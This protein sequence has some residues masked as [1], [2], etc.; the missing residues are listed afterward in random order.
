MINDLVSIIT[1]VYNGESWIL[2]CIKS[3]QN[4][5][6]KNWEMLIVDDFSTDKTR[7]VVR[8]TLI[9]QRIRLYSN[10]EN[11]GVS[12]SRNIAI[13]NA[14]GRYIAFLD[15]DDVWLPQKLEKQ[16]SFMKDNNFSFTFTGY[17]MFTNK[18]KII[19]EIKVPSII[20]YKDYLKNTIIGCL[21][22]MIDRQ[23]IQD[24]RCQEGSLEDVK[25]WM[26]LL[27]NYCS[28]YGLNESLALYRVTDNSVSSNKL[29]NAFLYY[30]CLKEHEKISYFKSIYYELCYIINA[31]KKRIKFKKKYSGE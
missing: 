5:T 22:V 6:Y 9:D 15:A 4:Q 26:F 24:F 1:P 23:Y 19:S 10:S 13:S 25:T 7:E 31:V 2:E 29:K 17:K 30:Q 14:K 21:T 28:A 20:N 16:L 3:V 8:E 12:F 11:K 27:K 18:N